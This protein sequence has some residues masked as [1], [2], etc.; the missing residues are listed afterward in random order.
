MVPVATVERH[1]LKAVAMV[2]AG[3][4]TGTVVAGLTYLL[5]K[6]PLEGH[7]LLVAALPVQVVLAD[8]KFIAVNFHGYAPF[9]R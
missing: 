8:G 5:Q 2:G 6:F 1:A 3:L 4:L 7:G 9:K